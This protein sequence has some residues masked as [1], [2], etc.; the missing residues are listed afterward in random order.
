MP[1]RARLHNLGLNR[2]KHR[3]VAEYASAREIMQPSWDAH[4]A[5]P[6]LFPEHIER[7]LQMLTF[8]RLLLTDLCLQSR[9]QRIGRNKKR[10]IMKQL[11]NEKGIK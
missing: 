2:A 1:H 5:D 3:D 10:R 11:F 9:I 4:Y 8:V 6:N 7:K